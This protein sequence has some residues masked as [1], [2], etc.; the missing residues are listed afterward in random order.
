MSYGTEGAW[1]EGPGEHSPGF[2]LGNPCKRDEALKGLAFWDVPPGCL[3]SGRP[4]RA[5]GDK[6]KTQDKPWAMLSGPFGPKTF[7][8]PSIFPPEAHNQFCNTSFGS[9]Q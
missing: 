4:F 3:V 6:P 7:L 9:R 5:S 8:Y 1:P 2:T